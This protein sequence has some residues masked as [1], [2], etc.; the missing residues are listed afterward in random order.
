M[1][2]S[3]G[4]L[5]TLSDLAEKGYQPQE[6]RYLLLSGNYRQSLN[7]TFDSLGAARKAIS[8]LTDFASKIDFE[9]DSGSSLKDDFGPFI[10]FR[11]LLSDLNTPEAL[12]K[13]FRLVREQTEAWNRGEFKDE[14]DKAK[15]L[16]NGFSHAWT[17]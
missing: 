11:R 17:L 3:L 10:Q 13:L 8:K 14:S 15:S 1:S 16:R 4:N 7:F 2:K 9:Y 12:G 6:I 5:Y